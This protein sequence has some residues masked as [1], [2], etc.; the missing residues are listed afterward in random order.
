MRLGSLGDP[1]LCLV[2]GGIARYGVLKVIDKHDWSFGL[3]LW[4][5]CR[6]HSL[7]IASGGGPPLPCGVGTP[8][9]SLGTCSTRS[10]HAGDSV[11]VL[12]LPSP[13][14]RD[15]HAA[16]GGVLPFWQ[17][18]SHNGISST[19]H[20]ARWTGRLAWS[21]AAMVAPSTGASP[22]PGNGRRRWLLE[23]LGVRLVFVCLC[24]ARR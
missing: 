21:F 23:S 8:S 15:I 18:R 10:P 11:A 1:C 7:P 16:V 3:L 19:W 6:G 14:G 17:G 2:Q 24:K 5:T 12:G 20:L 9:R 4:W 22:T 13:R